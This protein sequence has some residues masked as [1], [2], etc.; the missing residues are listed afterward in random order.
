ML[1]RVS[2]GTDLFDFPSG[3]RRRHSRPDVLPFLVATGRQ[4]L[5]KVLGFR[6]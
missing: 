3:E 5:A 6:R 4:K 2:A 1:V